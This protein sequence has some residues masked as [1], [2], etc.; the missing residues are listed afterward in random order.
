MR[1]INQ[2]IFKSS[3]LFL[4]FAFLS[5][6]CYAESN[7]GIWTSAGVEKK[8]AS[9]VSANF[10]TE[11]R[12]H[13]QVEVTDR[14]GFST[15][16]SY[17][18]YRNKRKTFSVKCNLDY[19]FIRSLEPSSI[20]L[21]NIVPD[22][23]GNNIQ[24]YNEDDAFWRSKHR[25]SLSLSAGLKLSRFRISLRERYRLTYYDGQYVKETRYRY[26]YVFDKLIAREEEIELKSAKQLNVLRSRMQIYYDIP[27][28]KINPFTSIEFF[29]DID[30]S[31]KLYKTRWRIGGGYTYNK[32]HN[33]VVYYQFQ[34]VS[35]QEEPGRHV[36]G[37]GYVFEI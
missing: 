12:M 15:G 23:E 4:L 13:N 36:V 5:L 22:K 30:N 6:Y 16:L 31:L 27:S 19:S 8:I 18:L 29:N 37:V 17:R 35:D 7:F 21:K 24:E 25:G 32:T 1:L 20:T 34:N 33:F 28:F 10:E 2:N 11:Y 3:V 14:F 26:S 9:G